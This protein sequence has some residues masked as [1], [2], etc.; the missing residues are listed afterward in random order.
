[1]TDKSRFMKNR[2][3]CG[4]ALAILL[5]CANVGLTGCCKADWEPVI[6]AVHVF[7]WGTDQETGRDVFRCSASLSTFAVPERETSGVSCCF[8]FSET[9]D[10]DVFRSYSASIIRHQLPFSRRFTLEALRHI[11]ADEFEE[12]KVYYLRVL[13][14]TNN[15]RTYFSKTYETIF[16]KE[17]Q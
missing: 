5:F 12:G 10:F 9:E 6:T 2:C 11:Y 14:I 16:D 1:M 4:I 7:F 15:G 8:E 3:F 13:V 17:N